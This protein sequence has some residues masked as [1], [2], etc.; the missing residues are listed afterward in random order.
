LGD[1]ERR[2]EEGKKGRREE[3]RKGGWEDERMGAWLGDSSRDFTIASPAA[4]NSEIFSQKGTL[5]F[6]ETHLQ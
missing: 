5:T 3:G 4:L 2:R 6:I 1:K